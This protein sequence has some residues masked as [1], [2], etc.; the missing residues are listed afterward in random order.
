MHEYFFIVQIT[1]KKIMFVI[2][3]GFS[4]DYNACIKSSYIEWNYLGLTTHCNR[5]FYELKKS[6]W[7]LA[8]MQ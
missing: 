3:L 5:N 7:E 4:I 8:I 1:T 2:D 6:K